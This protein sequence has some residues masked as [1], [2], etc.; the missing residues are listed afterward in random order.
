MTG[1]EQLLSVLKTLLAQIEEFDEN[2]QPKERAAATLRVE[3]E[4]DKIQAS[5]DG[6]TSSGAEQLKLM[7]IVRS[8]INTE[9]GEEEAQDWTDENLV[10]QHGYVTYAAKEYWDQV[11]S[12]GQY[13]ESFDWFGAW[14]A[15]SEDGRSLAELV[16]PVLPKDS[17][18]LILGCG[19]SNMS[20]LMYHEG[21]E[22]IV[23]VDISPPVIEQMQ[24]KHA[25]LEKMTWKAMDASQM[26]FP[27]GH[28]DAIV[29]KGMFDALF[30]GTGSKVQPVIAEAR[31]VLKS[32]GKV[33]S[34]S[35]DSDRIEK[36]FGLTPE[37]TELA[38]MGCG[39][40]GVLKFKAG[41][42]E[43]ERLGKQAGQYWVYDC[44]E[45]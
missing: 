40:A 38:P 18:I 35:F 16:R 4:L 41:T 32:G 31:R 17:R 14:D 39:T 43:T 23:N 2:E 26:E 28:F 45:P 36:L 7:A 19:N 9:Q 5:I 22:N 8:A 42:A 37:G 6:S 27:S 11:Y 1:Q 15:P 33:L 30:T 13:G 12:D 10:K 24:K 3:G 25:H 29:E 21:W 34:M 20:T 44:T